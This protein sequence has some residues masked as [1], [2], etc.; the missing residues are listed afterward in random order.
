[1]KPVAQKKKPY[2][3]VPK[4]FVLDRFGAKKTTIF[5]ICLSSFRRKIISFFGGRL[6]RDEPP[7]ISNGKKVAWL[8]CDPAFRS[9][10]FDIECLFL[11]S[12][13]GQLGKSAVWSTA[14]P[15]P[16]EIPCSPL[17]SWWHAWLRQSRGLHPDKNSFEMVRPW[18]NSNLESNYS[19]I[20]QFDKANLSW[21]RKWQI[22]FGSMIS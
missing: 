19:K 7:M 15:C 9:L 20:N 12:P 10:R 16:C 6:V 11:A 1:M 5:P 4:K 22:I 13:W 18:T 21:R 3:C 14:K 17:C 8:T 2:S